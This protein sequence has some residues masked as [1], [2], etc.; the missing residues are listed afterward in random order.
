M[1]EATT[2]HGITPERVNK[3]WRITVRRMT[4]R[5]FIGALLAAG[6][7]IALLG[8]SDRHGEPSP[9]PSEAPPHL[10]QVELPPKPAVRANVSPNARPA[11]EEP[12]RELAEFI[13]TE[14][15]GER[16]AA[17]RGPTAATQ[18]PEGGRMP[19]PAE[20]DKDRREALLS[21]LR[22]EGPRLD[23]AEAMERA[24][25]RLQELQKV[26]QSCK[27]RNLDLFGRQGF[28]HGQIDAPE[29]EEVE[30]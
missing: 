21:L 13:S 11:P 3:Q 12:A 30:Q 10:G 19:R 2:V 29:K 18:Q 7:T 26:Q 5:V 22:P 9:K 8:L 24:L 6:G 20:T 14:Q 15:A 23:A 25:E 28:A 4:G 16:K 17:D 27:N 1:S